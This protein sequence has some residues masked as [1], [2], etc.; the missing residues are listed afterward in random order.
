MKIDALITIVTFVLTVTYMLTLFINNRICILD[1]EIE[2]WK[3]A[4]MEAENIVNKSN[5]TVIG[6]V[7]IK[8]IY[9]NYTIKEKLE[10]FRQQKMGCAYTYRIW[11][12]G[13]LLYVEVCPY[14]ACKP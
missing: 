10:G 5:F 6:R 9:W 12:D 8:T 4:E 14:K 3:C 13:S 1:R 11:S 7:E 2:A